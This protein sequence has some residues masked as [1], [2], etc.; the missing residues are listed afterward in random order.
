[1]NSLMRVTQRFNSNFAPLGSALVKRKRFYKKVDVIREDPFFKVT[2]DGRVLKTQAGKPLKVDSEPLALAIAEEWASQN[3]NLEIGLMRLTGLAFTAHDNPLLCTKQSITDKLLE[4]LENDTILFY[5]DE[6]TNLHE[7][8]VKRWTPL[9][10]NANTELGTSLKPITN[11]MDTV[12]SNEDRKRFG[13]WLLSH[14]EWALHGLQYAVESVKSVLIPFNVLQWKVTAPEAVELAALER[15]VQ[16]QV[17]G[18]V[19]WAHG[20]EDEELLSRLSTACLFVYL[21]SNKMRT[22]DV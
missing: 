18:E 16:A 1:M 9:I 3:E 10:K 14:N 2:L 19:E 20:I 7:E 6:S 22:N 21:N 17:W 4:Y 8:Q 11:L 13:G 15:K 5:N 12:V